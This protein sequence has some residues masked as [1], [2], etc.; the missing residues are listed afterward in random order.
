MSHKKNIINLQQIDE[1]NYTPKPAKNAKGVLL[2]NS[3]I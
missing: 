2:Y 3:T 1:I